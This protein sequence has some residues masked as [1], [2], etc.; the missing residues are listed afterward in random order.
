MPSDQTAAL[1]GAH[2]SASAAWRVAAWLLRPWPKRRPNLSLHG[3]PLASSDQ[4]LADIGLTRHAVSSHDTR[5]SDP[6]SLIRYM[7]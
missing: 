3:T 2:P 1:D 7:R 5:F 4:L 6:W